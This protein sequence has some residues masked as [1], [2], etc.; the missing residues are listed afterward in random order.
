MSESHILSPEIVKAC[1]IRGVVGTDL[2]E[3]DAYAIG[4]AFGTMIGRMEK[5][6][7]I[8]GYDGR[9]SSPLLADE[10]VRGLQASGIDVLMIGLVPTPVVYYAVPF[11]HA[12]AGIIVTASHNPPEYNGFKFVLDDAVFHGDSIKQL[13]RIC[14]GADYDNGEGTLEKIDIIDDY[15]N[16]LYTFVSLR[17]GYAPSVVWDPGN[18][19]TAVV[20]DRFIAKIPGIHTIIC[21]K[22]DGDFPY[23]HPDPSLRGNMV[24]LQQKV[25]ELHADLGIAF[26]GD[27][28]RVGV[29]DNEGCIVSGD[30]LLTIYACDLLS[31]HPG[32][33]IMSEVKASRLFYDEVKAHG[34][35][36]IMW[37]V[38]HTNQKERMW[39]EG[40]PL[41]GETS[42]HIF[43]QENNGYD[44]ALFSAVKL[45]NIL[46][47]SQ[48]TLAAMRKEFP[49]YYNSGEIRLPLPADRRIKVIEQIRKQLETSDRSFTD[50]DGL[51]VPSGSGFWLLRGS[52]TQPHMTIRCEAA[53]KKGLEQCISDLREQL[54]L[55]G[56]DYDRQK[57]VM[58]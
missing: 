56:I 53:S 32:A 7:C 36:P 57:V 28:D 8:I 51:R 5:K 31:R 6:R 9:H 35:L 13:V 2:T 20:L 27:G 37:K 45:L 38:G 40:I 26:D 52:N 1:D 48:K 39:K 24:M 42:G 33:S 21:G 46:S 50:V 3:V 34:G 12:G 54:L 19:A 23:H 22:V 49:A 29:V 30:Q 44:D 17:K 47:S 43:F 58:E 18:G 41:A 16:Y 4:R 25:M 11:C 14:R 15:I 10:T 55:A